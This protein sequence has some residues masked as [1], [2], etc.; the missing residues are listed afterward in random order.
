MAL[1]HTLDRRTEQGVA[2]TIRRSLSS[3]LSHVLP[4]HHARPVHTTD[5]H[6]PR[7]MMYPRLPERRTRPEDLTASS[8]AAQPDQND[9]NQIISRAGPG[10]KARGNLSIQLLNIQSLLPKLAD[11]RTDVVH[12]SPEMLCFTETNLK[13]S[14]PNR[15]VTIPGYTL[16]RQ[17]RKIG[18]KKS[19]GGVAI[20]I[21]EHLS[22]EKVQVKSTS[23]S[24]LEVLWAKV[25]LDKK[26]A[27]TVGCAYRPP[28]TNHSQIQADF[29]DLEDQIQQIMATSSSHRMIIAGDLNADCH[30]NPVANARLKELERYG[31]NCVV[32]EPTFY[33]DSTKSIL[34]VI[35]LS[36]S[37]WNDQSPVTSYMFSRSMRLCEPSPSRLCGNNGAPR[38]KKGTVQNGPEVAKFRQQRVFGR[39]QEHCLAFCSK[40]K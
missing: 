19:G 8:T 40:T 17:D 30:T 37:L 38:Q 4:H 9:T 39:C 22:A 34:D 28:S 3:H 26:K 16:L 31:L 5:P 23:N 15:F 20:F 11:I 21:K 36:D 29:N 2:E 14:T 27:V 35:L 6:R 1:R 24:H 12:S 25:K 33:R 7:T 13:S 32:K 18:R 10:R